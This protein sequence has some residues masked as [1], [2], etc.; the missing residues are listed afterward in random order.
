MVA[1]PAKRQRGGQALDMIRSRT[2]EVAVLQCVLVEGDMGHGGRAFENLSA[3]DEGDFTYPETRA[4]FRAMQRRYEEGKHI[5]SATV[6]ESASKMAPADKVSEVCN[7]GAGVPDV[8]FLR[9]YVSDLREVRV[10]RDLASEVA[11]LTTKGIIQGLPVDELRS[12][13]SEMVDSIVSVS[14]TPIE[15]GK[16]WAKM[17]IDLHEGRAQHEHIPTGFNFLD[18]EMDGGWRKKFFNVI[19]GYSGTG[20]TNVMLHSAIAALENGNVV[21]YVSQEMTSDA[22]VERVAVALDD[23][24]PKFMTP[25]SVATYSNMIAAWGSRW[26]FTDQRMNVAQIEQFARD[27]RGING[28]IDILFVDY[29]QLTPLGRNLKDRYR[30]V[31][32]VAERLSALAKS[33]DC[34]VVVGAQLGRGAVAEEPNLTHLRESGDIE[35]TARVVVLLDRPYYREDVPKDEL[36]IFIAKQ[37]QGQVGIG[38]RY[39][40]VHGFNLQ[41]IKE[42]E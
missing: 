13:L 1:S 21:G 5:D 4:I 8:P 2:T 10:R 32:E 20:K 34:V 40:M 26:N 30:E 16:D 22:M 18:I 38:A 39:R 17:L 25:D 19:G 27:I 28:G 33:L 7:W 14:S 37:N 24:K 42:G 29:I 15:H 3:L 23:N 41:P 11:K 31:A 36:R 35:N 12:K 6:K 9:S